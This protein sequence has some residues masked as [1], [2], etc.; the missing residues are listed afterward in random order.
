[1]LFSCRRK[2]LRIARRKRSPAPSE[3]DNGRFGPLFFPCLAACLIQ[4]TFS[5]QLMS[6]GATSGYGCVNYTS[7]HVAYGNV[8]GPTV[9]VSVAD[10]IKEPPLYGGYKAMWTL[11]LAGACPS[12]VAGGSDAWR[13]KRQMT[14]NATAHQTGSSEGLHIYWYGGVPMGIV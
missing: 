14:S 4:R 6:L 3:S 9:G 1:M 2:I 13:S 12:S 10:I 8:I 5:S 7:T 11:V